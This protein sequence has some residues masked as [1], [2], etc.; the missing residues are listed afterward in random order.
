MRSYSQY[1]I[2]CMRLDGA[3]MNATI[4]P[5]TS[6]PL[7]ASARDRWRGA[8]A[9]T[10][11]MLAL[12]VVVIVLRQLTETVSLLD[13]MA[14]ALLRYLPMSMFSLSLD[15]FGTQAKTLLLAGLMAGLL[16]LGGVIGWR[17]ARSTSGRHPALG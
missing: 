11:G 15:L 5:S 6:H 16:V 2:S 1:S 10:L 3:L 9:G 13:A 8:A 17:Y 12:L 7:S 4:S 14:D